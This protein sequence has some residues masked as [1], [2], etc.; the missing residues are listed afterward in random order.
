M[1]Y[2]LLVQ[3]GK[4]ARNCHVQI[5]PGR[6]VLAVDMQLSTF[7]RKKDVMRSSGD[8]LMKRKSESEAY[9]SE[10]KLIYN[11]VYMFFGIQTFSRPSC[12]TYLLSESTNLKS[13]KSRLYFGIF[14]E[15]F[16]FRYLCAI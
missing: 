16:V 1:E 12:G 15:I 2:P 6:A 11:N 5:V 3:N 10:K 8:L 9:T 4:A 14:G 7:A 13:V